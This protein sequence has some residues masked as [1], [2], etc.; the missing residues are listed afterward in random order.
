MS[1]SRPSAEG[2]TRAGHTRSALDWAANSGLGPALAA[3]LAA[4]GRRRRT[5]RLG[6]AATALAAVLVM[7]NWIR[8]PA[9]PSAPAAESP[10]IVLLPS[11]R[12][13]PDGSLIELRADAEVEVDFAGEFRRIRLR[14]GT[15]HFT[16]AP[17]RTRPF[18][19]TAGGVEVRALGTAFAVELAGADIEVLVTEGTVALERAATPTHADAPPLA[20]LAARDC[21]RLE[22]EANGSPPPQERPAVAV[23][24]ENEIAERLAWRVPRLE[25]AGTR[26][27]EAVELLNRHGGSRLVLGSRALESLRVSGTIRADNPDALI[28]LIQ[29]NYDV[30]VTRTP[31]GEILLQPSP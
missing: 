21:V 10:A 26:L 7:A 16:V 17:D 14:H 15:A 8:E 28:D 23:L 13:L 5:R 1:S 2:E 9:T 11:S 25:F 22:R 30:R 18:V 3:E 4:R 20:V 24:G 19:V 12:A 31:T 29:A 6:L 27:A